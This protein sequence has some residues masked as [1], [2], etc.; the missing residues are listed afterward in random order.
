MVRHFLQ[1][2]EAYRALLACLDVRGRSVLELGAGNGAVTTLLI[3]AGAHVVAYEPDGQI[4]PL[5]GLGGIIRYADPTQADMSFLDRSWIVVSNAPYALL[6]WCLD[7]IDRYKVPTA[8]LMCP[9]D[10]KAALELSEFHT[11]FTLCGS[12]FCPPSRGLHA[13]MVRECA[14][15]VYR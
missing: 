5:P 15:P 9:K 2:F 3:D 8:V 6:P 11:A 4:Q 7:L 10:R 12:A 13:V 1:E 14:R